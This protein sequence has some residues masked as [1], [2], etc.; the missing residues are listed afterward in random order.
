M[1]KKNF[2][3]QNINMSNNTFKSSCKNTLSESSIRKDFLFPHLY[4]HII[5]PAEYQ[6]LHTLSDDELIK[7]IGQGDTYAGMYFVFYRHMD[8]IDNIATSRSRKWACDL[9][10]FKAQ[11]LSELQIAFNE[12]GW[13]NIAEKDQPKRWIILIIKNTA[14]KVLM[15][16]NNV[17][18]ITSS[19]DGEKIYISPFSTK[20]AIESDNGQD[21]NTVE[22][23]DRTSPSAFRADTY[24][25]EQYL[26]A[27]LSGLTPAQRRIVELRQI[28]GLSSKRT[29]QIMS[30]ELGKPINAANIDNQMSRSLKKM[31]LFAIKDA[32]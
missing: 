24:D 4:K 14:Y 29:A 28:N 7:L 10:S 13:E 21:R 17:K 32:A 8:V 30:Q 1:K 9:E 6:R 12:V 31:Q 22:L 3:K 26:Q 18:R 25:T 27:C 20:S 19:E 5:S 15:Q 11:M 2:E 16:E 23:F